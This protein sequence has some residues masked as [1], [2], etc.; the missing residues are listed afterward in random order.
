MDILQQG[1]KLLLQ[2]D[3]LGSLWQR[4]VGKYVKTS[5]YTPIQKDYSII[6][7]KGSSKYYSSYSI[8]IFPSQRVQFIFLNG[9]IKEISMYRYVLQ[10]LSIFS[11]Q[12][13]L[14]YRPERQAWSTVNK[15][16]YI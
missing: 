5:Q 10:I 7:S 6:K 2:S 12:E 3:R 8:L 16:S 1:L 9:H 13:G 4:K 15:Q 14:K 11:L